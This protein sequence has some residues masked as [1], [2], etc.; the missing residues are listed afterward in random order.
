MKFKGVT[1]NARTAVYLCLA[2]AF[3]I[4]LGMDPDGY[5]LRIVSMVV[6]FA[7]MA[8]AWNIVGGLANQLSLGHAAFFG[9]GA[10]TST[11][12]FIRQGISPWAGMLAGGVVAAVAMLLLSIPLFRLRGHYFAL[13]TLAFAEVLKIIAIHFADLTEGPTGITIPYGEPS[14]AN[15]Q[16][17]SNTSYYVVIVALFAVVSLIFWKLSTGAMGFRLRAIRENEQAAEV[18][19]IDTYRIKLGTSMVSAFTM[20]M[21]GTVYA[22]FTYFFDPES[23][24]SMTG[25]SVRVALICIIGGMGRL[26][27]PLIGAC[28]LIPLDEIAVNTMSDVAGLGPFVT[29]VILIAAIIYEPRGLISAWERLR[30]RAQKKHAAQSGQAAG[31]V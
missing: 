29:S 25:I 14:F 8:Q 18:S 6:L 2:V 22:Q 30:R 17:E 1:L 19:G 12:L 26:W 10:Y 5:L 24:F 13:A 20:G 16:F 15:F 3:L 23:I 4:P 9:L 21:C 7:A 11:L 31:A 28:I 27:G